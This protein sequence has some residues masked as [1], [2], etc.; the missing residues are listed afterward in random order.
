VVG[1]V[2]KWTCTECGTQGEAVNRTVAIALLTMH[3]GDAHNDV[4]WLG[5]DE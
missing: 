2:A 4:P 3:F 5:D 1:L